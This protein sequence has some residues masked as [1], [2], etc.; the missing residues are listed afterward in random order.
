M[1][2]DDDD[3]RETRPPKA[4]VIEVGRKIRSHLT[5][6]FKGVKISI[7]TYRW[8]NSVRCSV[9]IWLGDGPTEDEVKQSL[10]TVDLG[11]MHDRGFGTPYFRAKGTDFDIHCY[12]QTTEETEAWRREQADW[13]AVAAKYCVFE[14]PDA[15]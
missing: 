4:T 13:S 7:K 14:D 6:A 8:P 9:H 5:K 3:D 2:L 11:E 12:C 1:M 10:I 15:A